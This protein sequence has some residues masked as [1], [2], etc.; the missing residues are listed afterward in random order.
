M[1]QLKYVIIDDDLLAHSVILNLMQIHS[2]YECSGKFYNVKD[3]IEPIRKIKPD[4]IFL[5]IDMPNLKGFELLKYIDKSIKV[6]VTT[7]HRNYAAEGFDRGITDFL[8]KPIRQERL[9]EALNRINS[10]IETENKLKRSLFINDLKKDASSYICASRLKEKN[11]VQIE[12]KDIYYITKTGNHV[13][14]YTDTDGPYYKIESLK[15]IM[16]ILPEEDFSF[17]NQSYIFNV[18][19]A[20]CIDGESIVLDA[21]Q[22]II[23]K[24]SPIY[25]SF[26]KKTV[27]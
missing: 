9:F 14:I 23:I 6:I 16:Q 20:K 18:K 2:A 3:S 25:R 5:D 7:S 4:F 13:E 19:K 8:T 10:A 15:E 22:N 11:P 27:L 17:A 1:E 12:K 24:I 26:F 21:N